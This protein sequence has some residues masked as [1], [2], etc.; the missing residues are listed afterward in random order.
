MKFNKRKTCT[1]IALAISA[2]GPIPAMALPS[3]VGGGSSLLGPEISSE[4]AAFGTNPVALT[5]YSTS[6]GTGQ[7]A[8]LNN[9]A[10]YFGPALTGTVFFA[11]SDAAVSPEWLSSYNTN[12]E[13][14]DGP[15]IQIPYIVTPITVPYVNGPT[16]STDTLSGPQTTPGQT[17][18][19]A[20]NDSDL[21]GIFS[22]NYTNWNQVTNPDTGAWFNLNAPIKVIYDSNSSGTSEL[23]TRHLAAVC[24]S[25]SSTAYGVTFI[26]STTFAASFPSGVPSNFTDASGSGGIQAALLS[27]EST[28]TGAPSAIGYLGPDWANTFLAPSSSSASVNLSVTSLRNTTLNYDVAPTYQQAANAL[29]TVSAPS[30]Q[31]TAADPMQWVPNT[32]NP[33]TGYPI[34]G[35]SQILLSQC[36]AKPPRATSVINFLNFHYTTLASSSIINGNGF[37]T[38]PAAYEA[39]ITEDFLTNF[40]GYNLNIEGTG[41]CSGFTGR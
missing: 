12:D 21:C 39:A 19:L 23:L 28:S 13:P 25:Y 3:V 24:P 32:A 31:A 26:D 6:S 2:L 35:T 9:N 4:I 37:A 33:T 29:G 17:N 20:L 7:T 38:V 27:V 14:T 18:S 41:S 10:S 11:N 40:S 1:A 15:L 34:S 5:Y 16:S 30:T 22:G 36:Y 8:F